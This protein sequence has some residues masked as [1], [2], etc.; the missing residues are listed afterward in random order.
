MTLNKFSKII[1]SLPKAEK[2][3]VIFIGHGNPMNAIEENIY[4]K[5]WIELGKKL[6]KPKSILCISAHWLT[7]GTFVH[8]AKHP[9][10]IHD[11][12]GF[13]EE[14]YKFEY[15]CPGDPETAEKLK[16]L[17]KPLKIK[18]DMQ[19]GLDHGAWMPIS[20]LFPKA[21]IPVFEMSID[22]SKPSEFH[23][24]LG[25]EIKTLREKGVMI[26]GSGNIVHNLGRIHFDPDSKP[27]DWAEEFDALTKTLIE[28]RDH[29][30]L[31][32]YQNLGRAAELS[33]PTPDHY[34][35][36]LYILSLINKEENISFP[37]SGIAHGSVSMR[38]IMSD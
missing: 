4:S 3:P 38:A 16:S 25:K 7:S 8:K 22:I 6:D 15:N 33:I 11:F 5:K 1:E 10:T 35:P 9:K 37:V 34:W 32:N 29:K 27:Y 18:N 36:L 30:S 28:E 17:L 24:E 14:L 31:I 20:R 13:P 26:I 23:Y 12:W 19:W 2:Q 21:D